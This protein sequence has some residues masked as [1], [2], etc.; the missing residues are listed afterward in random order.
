MSV[1]RRRIFFRIRISFGVDWSVIC[2]Y[3]V[4]VFCFLLCFFVWVWVY[5]GFVMVRKRW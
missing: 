5:G 3:I 4:F 2:L 1:W